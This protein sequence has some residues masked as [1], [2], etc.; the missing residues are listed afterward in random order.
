MFEYFTVFLFNVSF[1]KCLKLLPK[2]RQWIMEIKFNV[3]F[4]LEILLLLLLGC[5]IVC[6]W[7]RW[8]E[9]EFRRTD[10]KQR[11]NMDRPIFV[12]IL[13]VFREE[14]FGSKV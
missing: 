8:T 7:Q 4:N 10:T 11:R 1:R 13:F 2:H 9:C 5:S 6:N 3:G 14:L 12:E